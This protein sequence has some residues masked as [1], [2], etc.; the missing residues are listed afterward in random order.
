MN[1]ITSGCRIENINILI[2]RRAYELYEAREKHPGHEHEDWVQTEREVK[3]HLG[4]Q[5]PKE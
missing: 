1:S 4:L 2:E 5:N 3:N